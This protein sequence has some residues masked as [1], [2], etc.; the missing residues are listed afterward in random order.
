MIFAFNSP[1]S[2]PSTG[3]SKSEPGETIKLRSPIIYYQEGLKKKWNFP[4]GS[5]GWLALRKFRFSILMGEK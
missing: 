1:T 3:I 4:R 2:P 5:G